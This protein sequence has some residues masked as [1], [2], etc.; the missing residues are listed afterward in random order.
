MSISM[1]F[2]TLLLAGFAALGLALLVA[3]GLLVRSA[4]RSR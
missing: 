3:L 4:I 1:V 2:A